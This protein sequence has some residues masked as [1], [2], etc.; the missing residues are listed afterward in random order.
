M[1]HIFI[2]HSSVD[3]YLGCFLDLT[4]VN[5]ATMNISVPASFWIIFSFQIFSQKC[6]C[7]IIWQLYFYFLRNLHNIF[8]HFYIQKIVRQ[9]SD[10]TKT[11]KNSV[12]SL[13]QTRKWQSN[14]NHKQNEKTTY[15]MGESTCKWCDWQ[16]INFQNT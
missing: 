4:I 16:E 15:R 10:P 6:D 8:P 9:C 5:S 14:R 1:Y 12:S 7:W 11:M 2:I 13:I 3:G